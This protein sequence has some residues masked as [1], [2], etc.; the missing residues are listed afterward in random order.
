MSAVE[1]PR[2]AF[3]DGARYDLWGTLRAGWRAVLRHREERRIVV[4]L[5]RKPPRLLRDMGMDPEQ[6][7]AALDGSWDEVDPASRRSG[8]LPRIEPV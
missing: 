4:A 8:D 5:S 7:Y 6:V 3:A 1:L 2:H